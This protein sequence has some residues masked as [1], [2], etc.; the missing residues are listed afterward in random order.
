MRVERRQALAA[1]ALG[2]T[3]GGRGLAA[4][5]AWQP[6]RPLRLVVPVPP[7]GRGRSPAAWRRAMPS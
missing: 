2:L 7:C 6:S 5:P 4:Q 1:L 3:A